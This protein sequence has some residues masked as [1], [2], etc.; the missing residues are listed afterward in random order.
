MTDP[1]APLAAQTAP[2][3]PIT[4]A[5]ADVPPPESSC[6]LEMNL[7]TPFG[8]IGSRSVF[9]SSKR[10]NTPSAPTRNATAGKN[11]RSELY[12]ICCARPMQSSCMNSEK[13]RFSAESHSAR[14]SRSGEEGERPTFA[15]SV[16][17]DKAEAAHL[18]LRL[19]FAAAPEDQTRGCADAAGD[20]EPNRDRACR[21]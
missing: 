12:A 7:I 9:T 13:L 2:K 21:D 8:A 17:V 19:A 18:G 11:A 5:A 15:R 16:A 4:N 20:E 6:R 1:I 10:S 14:L 3:K